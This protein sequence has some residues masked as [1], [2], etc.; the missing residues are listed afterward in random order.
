MERRFK[1]CLCRFRERATQ[2]HSL[3]SFSLSFL[4]FSSPVTW[5]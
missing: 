5:S 4:L 2:R 3:L 1:K